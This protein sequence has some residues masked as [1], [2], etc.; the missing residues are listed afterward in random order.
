M[1]QQ[2]SEQVPFFT[3]PTECVETN[4]PGVEHEQWLPREEEA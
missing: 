4:H 2:R 3:C 1:T